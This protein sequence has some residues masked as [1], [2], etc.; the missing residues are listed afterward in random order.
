MRR[1][2]AI[3]MAL[4]I[5]VLSLLISGCD[6][7]TNVVDDTSS[8]SYYLDAGLD[9]AQYTAFINQKLAPITNFL[10][11]S[12]INIRNIVNAQTKPANVISNAKEDLKEIKIIRDSI[13]DM[14]PADGFESNHKRTIR[15]INKIISLYNQ[16]IKLLEKNYI[17]PKYTTIQNELETQ[18]VEITNE[19]NN[20]YK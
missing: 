11:T 7:N 4:F 17:G 6:Y 8:S 19:F 2:I 16:Y 13:K 3:T 5:V 20:Y 14:K 12:M 9:T 10:T 15:N 1:I 18:Y